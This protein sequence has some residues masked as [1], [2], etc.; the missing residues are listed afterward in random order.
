[1]LTNCATDRDHAF[2]PDT[3]ADLKTAFR[4]IGQ[5]ISSLRIAK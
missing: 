4:A 2:F 1:M 3:G 5:E